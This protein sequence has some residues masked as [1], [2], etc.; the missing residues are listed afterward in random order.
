MVRIFLLVLFLAAYNISESIGNEGENWVIN[1]VIIEGNQRVEEDTI[2]NYIYVHKGD[3]FTYQ[4]M[5]ESLKS[6]FATGLF[7]DVSVKP[8]GNTIVVKVLENP[9][10]NQIAFEGNKKL[11][12]DDLIKEIS[13]KS[14]M[15]YNKSLL[16][17]DINHLVNIYHKMGRFAVSIVPKLIQ[18]PQNRVDLVFEIK[19]GP[20]TPI[21][22]IFFVGN[23]R[24]SDA[25]LS[26]L[27]NTKES[28]W[29][30]F[31]STSDNYDP[32]RLEYDKELLRR[33]YNSEGYPEF[34][35][36]SANSELTKD[37]SSFMITFS[38]E[39]GE[40][41]SFGTV[42][43]ENKLNT[44][45]NKQLSQEII[46]K[47]GE[48]YDYDQIEDSIDAMTK[49][50]NNNGFP[51]VSIEAVLDDNRQ[52][53]LI[54]IKYLIE[55]GKRV[56]LNKINISGNVRTRDQVI[57]REF[58][59][60][61]G[62]PYNASFI[63][64][65]EQR[66]KNLDYFDKVEFTPSSTQHPD[67]VDI[68]VDV[69]EKST[70]RI[71]LGGGYSTVDGIIGQIS[72]S[73]DNFLGR[74]QQVGVAFMKASKKLDIDFNFTEPYFMDKELAAGVE[75]FNNTADKKR[76]NPYKSVN[77]GVVP[78]IGY[79]INEYLYHSLRYTLRKD[80]ISDVDKDAS[81]FI[82]EQQGK[83]IISSIGQSFVY[84]KT[85]NRISPTKGYL[86]K[87]D[88]EIAGLGGNSRFFRNEGN[89]RYYIP[90]RR[91]GD[92]V[93]KLSGN[94]GY[95]AGLGKDV[96]INERFFI[97]DIGSY[98]FRGF[99]M[100]GIGPIVRSSFSS[101]REPL[102][103]NAYYIGTAELSFPFGLPK[104]LDI[105]G[106]L[107]TDVGSAFGV[108]IKK[109]D[110]N[111]NKGRI[112]DD[113]SLRMS[114][115]TGIVWLTR[116]GPIRMDFAYPVMKKKYDKSQYFHISFATSF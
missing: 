26:A 15:V 99:A 29:Y 100:G 48:I 88:Q 11:K 50:L 36:I 82:K 54:N 86:L 91:S 113:K 73:E 83:N 33:F 20:K 81:Y 79:S 49:L 77:I 104:D 19:E 7:S 23:K 67:R 32:D 31:F 78:N 35:I 55:E 39:E 62:D 69:E 60:A 17:Q 94:A 53:H 4:A 74:G 97:G 75:L 41:Y 44:E 109:S 105:S 47:K 95:I 110:K 1:S 12:Y 5:D 51:F 80:K 102:G 106:S 103:S 46:T 108:D 71:N 70:A 38:L 40:R 66:I 56:Y 57:R 115:G 28:R 112:W 92:I 16:Q 9:T 8:K 85:D 10:I 93:L 24:F 111:I 90:I 34:K 59:I 107:F 114:V 96:R 87:L 27:I 14:R 65:S 84:D 61:E 68:N 101:Q 45:Y 13:L 42:E 37:R 2:L 116:I 63:N 21:R 43:I 22:K 98:G 25:K 76:W 18:L 6:L 30:R 3:K 64:R 52:D 89:V 72:I 58:R